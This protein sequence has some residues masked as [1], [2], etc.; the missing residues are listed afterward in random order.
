MLTVTMLKR[1]TIL[2]VFCSF[3]NV[4]ECCVIGTILSVTV[5]YMVSEYFT[6]KIFAYVLNTDYYLKLCWMEYYIC[7]IAWR[8]C[9]WC[10]FYG[11]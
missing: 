10:E 4:P 5:L 8:Q 2:P 3:S 11:V 6:Q 1:F 7:N 9:L